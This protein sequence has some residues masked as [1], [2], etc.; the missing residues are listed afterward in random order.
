M[1]SSAAMSAS[2][3]SSDE[4][5][6]KDRPEPQGGSDESDTSATEGEEAQADD[7]QSDDDAAAESEKAVEEGDESAPPTEPATEVAAA[8]SRATIDR[9]PPTR[10][11]LF[12]VASI[13][14]LTYVWWGGSKLVCN[15]HPFESHPPDPMTP[16]QM[17][18]DPKHAAIEFQH[19]IAI[20]DFEAALSLSE[21]DATAEIQKLRTSTPAE[22]C[23]ERRRFAPR[24]LSWGELLTKDRQTATARVH[25]RFNDVEETSIVQLERKGAMWKAL[26]RLPQ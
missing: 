11:H 2:S 20:C 3:P 19:R 8:P 26:N 15:Y 7:E 16:Q 25:S 13:V 9:L 18:R 14:A 17:A 1:K 21:G 23:E 24:V 6:E 4:K 5:D 12:V 10:T 22:F